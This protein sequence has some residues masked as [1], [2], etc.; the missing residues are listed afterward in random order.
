[1]L[2][3]ISELCGRARGRQ[4][5]LNKVSWRYML[6]RDRCWCE[7]SRCRDETLRSAA[8]RRHTSGTGV[9]SGSANL[10][11]TGCFPVKITNNWLVFQC[12]VNWA[13][14]RLISAF[15]V[16]GAQASR[17]VYSAFSDRWLKWMQKELTNGQTGFHGENQ[18]DCGAISPLWSPDLIPDL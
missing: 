3:L 11:K 10:E 5:D 4:G 15:I 8:T 2:C 12:T 18:S 17:G 9:V 13:R 7:Q 1:M 6:I 14:A 16:V